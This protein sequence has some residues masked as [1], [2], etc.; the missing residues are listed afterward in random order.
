MYVYSLVVLWYALHGHKPAIVTQRRLSA[1]WDLSKTDPSFADMRS[2]L[3]RTIIG[4]RFMSSRPAQPP[5]AEIRPV[6]HA[7]A[8]PAAQ[9]RKPSNSAPH[10]C[11]AASRP[12]RRS[13]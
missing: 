11:A 8:L 7:W 3:R 1:P 4:A 2:T 9:R 12:D 6:H 13:G 10:T 5:T